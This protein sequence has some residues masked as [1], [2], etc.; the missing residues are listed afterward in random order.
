L[1][2]RDLPATPLEQ[3]LGGLL[4]TPDREPA[5]N[6]LCPGLKRCFAHAV[7]TAKRLAAQLNAAGVCRIALFGRFFQVR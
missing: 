4:R 3:S 5:P 2:I 1:R 6:L 7:P